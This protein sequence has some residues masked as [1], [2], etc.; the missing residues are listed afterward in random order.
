MMY[1]DGMEEI[2][3]RHWSPHEVCHFFQT[4]L[5]TLFQEEDEIHLFYGIVDHRALEL[6]YF[7]CGSMGAFFF[8]SSPSPS[9]SQKGRIGLPASS[10]EP[11]SVLRKLPLSSLKV[12]LSPQDKLILASYGLHQLKPFPKKG[13]KGTVFGKGALREIIRLNGGI[14]GDTLRDKILIQARDY[15]KVKQGSLWPR[16]VSVGVVEVESESRR[17]GQGLRVMRS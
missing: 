8:S 6:E 16:D 14:K 15:A 5:K 1:L 10:P 12:S 9:H 2:R 13:Q 7:F 4:K 11:F 17:L 3:Q